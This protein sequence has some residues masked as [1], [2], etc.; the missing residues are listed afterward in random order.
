M[1][2]RKPQPSP[3]LL[4]HSHVV[5]PQPSFLDK[6]NDILTG[7]PPQA[8][9]ILAPRIAVAL[10]EAQVATRLLTPLEVSRETES[11]SPPLVQLS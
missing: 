6:A 9:A 2:R 11:A 8:A 10:L 1:A 4:L 7:L 3:L 5:D